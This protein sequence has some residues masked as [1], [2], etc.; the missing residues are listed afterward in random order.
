MNTSMSGRVFIG[1]IRDIAN[2]ESTL[3]HNFGYSQKLE[4]L[5]RMLDISDTM[6]FINHSKHG[7]YV[8]FSKDNGKTEQFIKDITIQDLDSMAREIYDWCSLKGVFNG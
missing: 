2:K 8:S 6:A 4:D 1:N 5:G 3:D 7:L